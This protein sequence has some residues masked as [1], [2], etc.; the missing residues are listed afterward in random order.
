MI[1]PSHFPG[2]SFSV[3]EQL[4][5][6]QFA[7]TT[8]RNR[9]RQKGKKSKTIQQTQFRECN[10]SAKWIS[11]IKKLLVFRDTFS[12][13]DSTVPAWITVTCSSL[14]KFCRVK[15]LI[16]RHRSNTSMFYSRNAHFSYPIITQNVKLFHKVRNDDVLHKNTYP[17]SINKIDEAVNFVNVIYTVVIVVLRHANPCYITKVYWS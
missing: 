11:V 1:L 8:V 7:S 14:R 13:K 16:V 10:V 2:Q 12:H 6:C 9:F 17:N 3:L 4:Q 5:C 15:R